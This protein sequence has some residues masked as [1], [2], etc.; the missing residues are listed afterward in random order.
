MGI[1][2]EKRLLQAIFR[3]KGPE[4]V[5]VFSDVNPSRR[6]KPDSCGGGGVPERGPN[7]YVRSTLFGFS[8]AISRLNSPSPA[9]LSREKIEVRG[10]RCTWIPAR[11][12]GEV[13]PLF[14]D[15]R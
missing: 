4:V 2:S 13:G 12:L 14:S 6:G 15:S 10:L 8:H 9:S 5:W 7:G 1:F 11:A 3:L